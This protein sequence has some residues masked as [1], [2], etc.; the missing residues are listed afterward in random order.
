[1]GKQDLLTPT[2]VISDCPLQ[3]DYTF[4]E[5]TPVFKNTRNPQIHSPMTQDQG[6]VKVKLYT[7]HLVVA[8]PPLRDNRFF[9][10]ICSK[11]SGVFIDSTAQQTL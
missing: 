1:M 6:E 4:F 9:L 8:G 3:S 7:M 11:Y 10:L 5:P 2:H